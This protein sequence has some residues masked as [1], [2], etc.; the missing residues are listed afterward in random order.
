[1]EIFRPLTWNTPFFAPYAALSSRLSSSPVTVTGEELKR[2]LNAAYGAKKGVFQVSGLKLS[3]A[4]CPGQGRLKNYTLSDGKQ[5]Q[6]EKRYRV[7]MPDFL[8]R[9]G[10]GLGPVLQSLP[11]GRI[12]LG[13]S[14]EHNFR[15]SLVAY[16][17][18]N[19]KP[20]VAPKLGRIAFVDDGNSCNP[21]E[22]LE[23]H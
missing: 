15:D 9:G 12:D 8:A 11:P 23:R 17:T 22:K 19:Q 1:M 4:K 7:A 16:W 10:D 6:A 13:M 21:G 5:V 3:I 18:K 20:L 2:L 14:R